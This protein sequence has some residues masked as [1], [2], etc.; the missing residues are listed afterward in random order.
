MS[1]RQGVKFAIQI[2]SDW[3][4]MG[5]IWDFLRSVSV[6]FGAPGFMKVSGLLLNNPTVGVCLDKENRFT[7]TNE[8]CEKKYVI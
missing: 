1:V 2:G 5:Q 3:P 6:H 8:I 4:N 7:K